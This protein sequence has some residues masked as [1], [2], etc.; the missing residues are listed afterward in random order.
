MMLELQDAGCHNVNWV[1]PTHVLP[2]ALEALSLAALS[3]F[4]LPIVYNTGGYD[5]LQSLELLEGVVDI[6][7]PDFKFWDPGVSRRFLGLDD[8]PEVARAAIHEMH[9]QVGD[10]ILDDQGVARRGLL[11]RHLVMPGGLAGT[12][13]V[14]G[15][16]AA[17]VSRDTFVNIMPQ[18]HPAGAV[19]APGGLASHMDIARPITSKEYRE[20]LE[21]ARR[22][23]LRRL[24]RR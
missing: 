23:G 12:D 14:L 8:Y 18:Y 1:T 13:V 2:Q 22:A 5:A 7:M 17:E 3:G 4:R 19:L 10:L 11:V 24:D 20:A 16:L 15:W 6:Y 9:R 21:A